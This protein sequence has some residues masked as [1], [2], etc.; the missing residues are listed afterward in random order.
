G[1]AAVGAFARALAGLP[2]RD[3][4]GPGAHDWSA[5]HAA[6]LRSSDAEAAA[7]QA[8]ADRQHG[9]SPGGGVHPVEVV[10]A[11]E[12]HLPADAVVTNDAG[13]FSVFAHR[14]RRFTR[15]R[16]QLGPVSGAMGYGLPAAIGASLAAPGRPVV[17]LAGDGGFLMTA[18]ELETAVRVGAPVLCVVFVNGSYGT[19]AMHQARRFGR[20]AATDIGPV[21]VA[22]LARSL[23]AD[24]VTVTDPA[25]LDDVLAA[26]ARFD[27]PRV[28]AVRTDPDVLVPGV[29]LSGLVR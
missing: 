15:P 5:A 20:T 4:A 13:N 3:G 7:A 25:D 10:A 16:T 18:V 23:G 22:T 26:A 8:R 28:V 9:A 24:G 1:R 21:D 2:G 29:R 17:A 6:Y 12:R 11:L 19:I 27:A 14:Y